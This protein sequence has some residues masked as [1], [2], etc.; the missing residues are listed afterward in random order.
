M[1]TDTKIVK[2]TKVLPCIDDVSF[3][4]VSADWYRRNVDMDYRGEDAVDIVQIDYDYKLYAMPV[5]MTLNEF[6]YKSVSEL[7]ALLEI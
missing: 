1:D 7:K 2:L 5:Y 3:R 6:K 4:N